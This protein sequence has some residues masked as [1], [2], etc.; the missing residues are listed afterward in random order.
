M[1]CSGMGFNTS[2]GLKMIISILE[3]ILILLTLY[4]AS[5]YYKKIHLDKAPNINN[6][7]L[8]TSSKNVKIILGLLAISFFDFIYMYGIVPG[9]NAIAVKLLLI[10][11]GILLAIL[12]IL[13]KKE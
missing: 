11:H 12:L 6:F 10:T 5:K 13:K 4:I 8:M 7:L 3:A 9:N 2:R 1:G